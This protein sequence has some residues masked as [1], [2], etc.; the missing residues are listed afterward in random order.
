MRLIATMLI[1]TLCAPLTA[2]ADQRPAT[3]DVEIKAWQEVVAAI[4]PGT[5]VKLQ[6]A[7]GQRLTATLMSADS[8]GILVKRITRVPEPAIAIRF[9]E[10]A[11]LE[12]DEGRG[13]SVGKAIGIGLA[14]GAG[15][16]LTLIGFFYAVGD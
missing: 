10:I 11:R 8:D 2:R 4:P 12:R 5:R 3:S 7:G 9:S 1:V 16:I 13:M 6:T 15:A 14:A